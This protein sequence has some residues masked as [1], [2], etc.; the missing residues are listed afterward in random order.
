[1]IY[2]SIS[3]S[4]KNLPEHLKND[5]LGIP[6]P[7]QFSREPPINTSISHISTEFITEGMSKKNNKNFVKY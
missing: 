4:D 6:D 5:S 1:M 3:D 7:S 2:F